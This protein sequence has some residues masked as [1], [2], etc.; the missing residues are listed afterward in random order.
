[1][2]NPNYE[3]IDAYINSCEPDIQIILKELRDFIREL[4]P[5]GKE[6][7]SWGMPTYYLNGNLFHFFAHKKHMGFYPGASGIEKFTEDFKQRGYK[8]SKGA[9]QFPLNKPM[10]YDLI[11][12]IAKFRIE[13]NTR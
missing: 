12:K 2:S 5:E 3:S 11:E 9:V 10:P 7:I 4:V 6:K 13:E 8:F 1:M